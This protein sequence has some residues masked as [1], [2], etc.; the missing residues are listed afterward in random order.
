MVFSFVASTAQH[1]AT[2][3]RIGRA[4]GL[5]VRFE[6]NCGRLEFFDAGRDSAA[7]TYATQEA[8]DQAL[9]DSIGP[10]MR[11]R[12]RQR[13]VEIQKRYAHFFENP[14]EPILRAGVESRNAV[15]HSIA[16]DVCDGLMADHSEWCGY[17]EQLIRQHARNIAAADLLVAVILRTE[18]PG[19][20]PPTPDELRTY[21]ERAVTW[22]MTGQE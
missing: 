2:Q 5:G 16:S 4:L 9:L 14:I 20:D 7:R 19:E 21:V 12:L 8:K 13:S 1:T 10:L 17:Q 22:V 3:A 11:R 18:M 6:S 15:A